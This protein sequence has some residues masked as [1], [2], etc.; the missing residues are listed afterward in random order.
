MIMLTFNNILEA[1][2]RLQ[3]VAH[4]T[5]VLTSRQFNEHS[6]CEVFFKAENLQRA[7]AF[8]FRGAYNKLAS[9]TDEGRK[10]GALAYSSGNHAQATALA[11]RLLG[12]QVAIVMPQDAPQIKVAAT[13]AYG[14]EVIFY[15]RYRES[16]EEIGERISR[17]RGMTLVP[18]FDD[19]AVM[20]GQGTAALELLEEVPEL[21]LLLVPTSG[22]GLLAGCAVAACH[23]RPQI[24]VFGVE[25]EA[26]NDTW[27][28]FR[29]GER[30]EIPVP[31]TIA[32]GLQVTAPGKLT[33]PIIRELVED[34]LL[35]NDQELISTVRFVLER[36]KVL[37]EPSGAAAAAAVFHHKF[38]FT[39][40]RVGV[41]L[42]GGNVDLSKLASYL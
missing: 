25:P 6:A 28:S 5:P 30:V 19:Y 14:A 32:D 11:A 4:R 29:K 24:R 7:G 41:L 18:P 37:V 36:M 34:I 22:S 38:D 33:F 35:V 3:G 31:K 12:I 1:R 42:S 13:R 9:L 8:K 23:M 21:D 27:Q 17:E 40:K 10:R 2:E 20:A 39:G 16:R 26:G 15:D